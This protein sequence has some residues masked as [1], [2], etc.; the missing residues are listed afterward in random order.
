MGRGWCLAASL[1]GAA[2]ALTPAALAAD[3]SDKDERVLLRI[4]TVA[5]EG[6]PWL[7]GL[8]EMCGRIEKN[9]SSKVRCRVFGGA[10]R[11]DEIG[12]VKAVLEGGL[13]GYAGSAGGL[14]PAV[15]EIAVL[16]L[17]FL[18]ETEDEADRVLDVVRPRI[19]AILRKRGLQFI[20]MSEVGFR[21]LATTRPVQ[22]IDDLSGLRVRSMENPVHADMW[23][24][25]GADP[26]QLGITHVLGALE[27]GR[28]Q[29]A[30]HAPSYAFGASW[31]Q[32]ARHFL[33]TR[34]M[35]QPGVFAVSARFFEKLPKA[36][37]KHFS[38]GIPEVARIMRE[39]VRTLNREVLGMLP[40]AGVA[41]RPLDPTL[42]EQ[43]AQ[44]AKPLR[45]Q[46]RKAQGRAGRE[47]LEAVES[48]L[49]RLRR[50]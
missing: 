34:H 30:D 39:R 16:E 15:P 26:V 38:E 17:P 47:L 20:E 18:F 10:I 27:E 23:K 32:P 48:E 19:A 45:E 1:L 14:V 8:Q 4:A 22:R 13:E 46:F 5:T 2:L 11:G 7:V 43:L 41:V 50:R 3:P 21:S 44:R 40:S 36:A 9:T 25:F 35:Y 24:R 33:L 31:F 49:A 12:Q 29:G 6:S 28:V 42:R 37:Q